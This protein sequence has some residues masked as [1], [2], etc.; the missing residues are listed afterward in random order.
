M[1]FRSARADVVGT[2]YESMFHAADQA[3]YYCK[4]SGRGQYHFY[5]STME[6]MLSA[7]SQIEENND[8]RY[9]DAKPDAG[10]N[11]ERKDEQ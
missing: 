10:Q 9:G 2:D 5:N 11:P 3:L 4:R 7:I 6:D 8:D 1:L